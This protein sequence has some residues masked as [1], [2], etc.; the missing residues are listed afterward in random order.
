MGPPEGDEEPRNTTPGSSVSQK[1]DVSSNPLP[2]EKEDEGSPIISNSDRD[3]GPGRTP[4]HDGGQEDA[5]SGHR[6]SVGNI[7]LSNCKNDE[8]SHASTPPISNTAGDAPNSIRQHEITA[9]GGRDSE[10]ISPP[11]NKFTRGGRG[12]TWSCGHCNSGSMDIVLD[13]HCIYCGRR[14]DAYSSPPVTSPRVRR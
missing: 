8:G 3:G 1:G 10:N 13:I 9:S 4:K 7:A 5:P 11:V 6:I 12:T 14:R 2:S